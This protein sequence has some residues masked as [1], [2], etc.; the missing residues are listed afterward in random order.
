MERYEVQ[1]LDSY[2]NVTYPDGQAAAIYGQFPPLVNA[3]RPPGEWQ[4][5][6]IVFTAPRFTNDTLAS[7]A[8]ATVLHN[9]VVVHHDVTLLGATVHRALGTYQAHPD[10]ASIKLQDH[11]NPIRFRNIWARRLKGYDAR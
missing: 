8:H 2:R 6:D 11:G 7:P 5:Y 4:T 9:G 3:S 10:M 1:V